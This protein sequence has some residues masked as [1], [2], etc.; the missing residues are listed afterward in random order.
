M[1]IRLQ[2]NMLR[3]GKVTGKNTHT[4]EESERERDHHIMEIWQV[5]SKYLT[6]NN[7]LT[8]II[9]QQRSC[10]RLWRIS[11]CHVYFSVIRVFFLLF[12][13]FCVFNLNC[14]SLNA[15]KAWCC[16]SLEI[17]IISRIKLLHFSRLYEKTAFNSSSTIKP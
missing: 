10:E 3:M 1:K 11:H 9:R 6:Q 12:F 16:V 13:I 15:L 4:N 7:L 14:F 8:S 2:N 5:S 17:L